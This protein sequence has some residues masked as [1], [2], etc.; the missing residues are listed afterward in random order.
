MGNPKQSKWDRAKEYVLAHPDMSKAE[1]A[2]GAGV[3]IATIAAVRSALVR[4]KLIPAS[5]KQNMTG[6]PPQR[7]P[8][9][10]TDIPSTTSSVETGLGGTSALRDDAAMRA[11]A[12]QDDILDANL[13]DEEVVKRLLRQNL[14]F[15][16]DTSLHPDT[17]MTASQQWVKL[18]DLAKEKN[19]GAGKPVTFEVAVERLGALMLACGAD[20]TLA[21]LRATYQISEV[22]DVTD[23]PNAGKTAPLPPEQQQGELPPSQGV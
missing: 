3:A 8:R 1:Q 7:P 23:D 16:S 10:I 18:R 2:L 15:A 6:V 20:I 17:R 22:A 12:A 5:R 21:A 13:S 9:S 14:L 19:L 11:I 4:D